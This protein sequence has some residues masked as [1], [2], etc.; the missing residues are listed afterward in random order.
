VKAVPSASRT[1]V[2]DI[3]DGRL[4]VRIAAAPE[5][6]KANIEL[7]TALAKIAGC[8]KSAVEI[9]SGEKARL[10]TLSFPRE[11]E[12]ALRSLIESASD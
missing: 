12:A 6:G 9:V 3:K 5:D 4:R 7:R 8:A 10:K 11:C 2:A 1:E